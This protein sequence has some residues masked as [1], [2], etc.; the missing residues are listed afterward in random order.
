MPLTLMEEE[1][2][3]ETSFI[4]EEL[5]PDDLLKFAWQIASGMVNT[6]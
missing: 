1:A 2:Q 3:K 4:E 5:T 6:V